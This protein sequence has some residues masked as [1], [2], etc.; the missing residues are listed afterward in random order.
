MSTAIYS[1]VQAGDN[2]TAFQWV[3]VVVLISFAV[4]MLMNYWTSNQLKRTRR[5]SKKKRGADS[6]VVC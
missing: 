1:A 4:I 5:L 3:I 6:G 2:E